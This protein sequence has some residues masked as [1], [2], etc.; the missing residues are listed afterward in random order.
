MCDKVHPRKPPKSSGIYSAPTSN[1]LACH[2]QINTIQPGTI[3]PD[4]F[5]ASVLYY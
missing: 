3:M 4:T 5:L 1:A 2:K